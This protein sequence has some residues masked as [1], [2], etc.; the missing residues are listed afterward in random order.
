M[1]TLIKTA[2]AALFVLVLAS[3]GGG[4]KDEKSAVN[5]KKAELEKMKAEQR[6]LAA[7]IAKLEGEIAKLDPTAAREEK[8]KLVALTALSKG[9]FTHYIDLQGMVE[10]ENIA[11]VTPRG[12]GGQVK[13]LY[14]KQGQAVK[15]GQLLMKLDDAVERKQIDQVETQLAFAED[16][17]KR[18]QNLWS[19]SIGTEVQLLS[20]KNNVEQLKKQLALAQEQLS[21]TNVYAEMAGVADQVTI[22]VGEAFSATSASMRGIRIVNSGNLKT[23]VNV[24]ENYLG[25]VGVGSTMLVQLPESNKTITTRVSV[26]GPVIDP[27]SRSFYVEAPVPG[28]GFRPNQIALVRI[29]DYS[30]PSV[31][32]IPVNTLQNDD[33][34]KFVLV[35]IKE[36][37]RLIARKK[38]VDIGELYGD[39]LEVKSGLAEGD[40]L[41][42]EGFQGLY[43]GQ[44][45][46]TSVK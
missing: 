32:T 8:S 30:A 5:D 2:A 12:M 11:Y 26:S 29:Q 40:Q 7:N 41:I 25:R 4:G 43:D 15:K 42:T 18:Q 31:I 35:A 6:T 17:Y 13:A 10:S 20:A 38:R 36:G 14:V 22:K 45:L 34:G 16:L 24:P 28:G 33:Q 44:P 46:T 1:H 37:N 3:C 23:V 27:L 39:K 19:Q 9:E 21:F